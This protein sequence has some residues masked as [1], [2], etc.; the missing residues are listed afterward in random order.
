MWSL[1]SWF[2]FHYFHNTWMTLL[3]LTNDFHNDASGWAGRPFLLKYY[4]SY[5]RFNFASR[6]SGNFYYNTPSGIFS[7]YTWYYCSVSMDY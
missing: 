5:L 1:T 3:R 4:P 7:Y 2:Q 6:F